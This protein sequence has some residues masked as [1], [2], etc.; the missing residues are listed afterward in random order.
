VRYRRIDPDRFLEVL[1]L[2]KQLVNGCNEDD[3]RIS[4]RGRH[5]DMMHVLNQVGPGTR[6]IYLELLRRFCAWWV[7][8]GRLDNDPIRLLRPVN[9]EVDVRH[10][11]RALHGPASLGSAVRHRCPAPYGRRQAS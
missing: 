8:M 4:K 2:R 6:N 7:N 5:G 9:T 10:Q 3:G 11:R 1:A